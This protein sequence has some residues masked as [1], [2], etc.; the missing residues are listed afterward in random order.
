MADRSLTHDWD[1]RNERKSPDMTKQANGSEIPAIRKAAVIGA[2]VGAATE[3]AKGAG[4]QDA[5]FSGIRSS[6]EDANHAAW[7]TADR[8]EPSVIPALCKLLTA[9]KPNVRKA[10]EEALKNIVHSVGKVI[11]PR[12]LSAN[13]GRPDSPGTMDRRQQVVMHFLSI[14]ESNCPEI[15]K[16]T[17]LRHLSLIATTDAIARIAALIDD[18]QLREEVV[19]CLERIPGKTSEEALLQALPFAADDF[20][21]RVL[22]AL[23][24]RRAGEAVGAC[25]EAMASADSS[26][27]M[28]GMKAWGRIGTVTGAEIDFPDQD[29][30]DEWQQIE[31]SDSLLRFADAQLEKGNVDEAEKLYREALNRKEE[32]LQCAAII[33]L[34]KIGTAEAAAAI[35]PKL[36]SPEHTVRITARQAW[37]RLGEGAGKG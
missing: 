9:E 12:S 4:P 29:S 33:G 27:A 25:I 26:I 3:T 2:A 22:A 35:F 23:G 8:M 16:T 6:D 11:D 19:F 37:A 34:A 36:S 13:V 14:L 24:H 5:F 31:F 21:P 18:P 1:M 32:H 10:A 20:K 28:A 17:A 30:L 7:S 15:E